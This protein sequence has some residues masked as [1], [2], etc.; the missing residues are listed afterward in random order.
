MKGCL[1]APKSL[2]ALEILNGGTNIHC[3]S[4]FQLLFSPCH[5]FL[6][7][8]RKHSLAMSTSGKMLRIAS[9]Q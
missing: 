5:G 6:P 3:S 7:L 8:Q 2:P 9:W 4:T 1:A